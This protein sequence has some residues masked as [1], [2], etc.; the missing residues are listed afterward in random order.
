M[1]NLRP[2]SNTPLP[3]KI[4]EKHIK[5]IIYNYM[6]SHNLSF[7][8]Q[9]GFRKG[10]STIKAVNEVVNHLYD[11]RNKGEHSI[12]VFLDLSKACNSINHY[13]LF[14]MLDKLGITGECKIWITEYLRDRKQ[15]VK[16]CGIESDLKTINYGIPQGTVLGPLIYLLYVNDIGNSNVKSDVI[17]FADDTAIIAHDTHLANAVSQIV[18][19]VGRLSDWFCFN[20]LTLN[21]DKTKCMYFSKSVYE[22]NESIEVNIKGVRLEFVTKFSYLGIVIDRKLQF[23]DHIKNSIK[24]AGH[25]VYI[26][27][28]IRQYINKKTALIIFKSIILP[29]MEYGNIFHGTCTKLYKHKLQ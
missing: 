27:S 13:I 19:D 5:N 16:N 8:N 23:N 10:K 6:E 9:N 20:K 21:L 4:L 25:K 26:L 17:M 3:S 1:N 24:Q 28:K 11:Y 22:E 12:A 2:I 14:K 29:Y 7:K 18:D 15:F